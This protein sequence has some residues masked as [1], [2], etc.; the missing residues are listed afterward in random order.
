MA[1]FGFGK[2]AP[3]RIEP[4]FTPRASLENPATSLSDPAQWFTDWATGGNGQSFGPAI[5]ERTAMAVSAVYRCVT[6]YMGVIAGLSPKVYQRTPDGRVEV[7]GN[8]LARLLNVA[9]YPGRS[10]T[11]FAWRELAVCNVLLWGNHYSII[12]YDN[13]ARVIGFEPVMPWSVEVFRRA[14]R[15]IYRC[16][17]EDGSVE[18]IDQ[19]D[20]LH[21][22][23]PGF[24]GILGQSRIASQARDA[25]ALA[26][27]LEQQT[28]KI[29]ENAAR[30]SGVM[31][32]PDKI[33]PE[34]MAR[35]R[36]QFSQQHAGR[37]NAGK[38]IF[39]AKD[40]KF[41][42]IQLSPVDLATI[43]SR[44]YQVAD[45]SRFFGVPLHL[46]NETDKSTSWGSGLA[47]QNLAWL[48]YG[49]DAEICRIEAELNY[50]LMDGTDTYIE[51]HRD[52]LLQMDPA[53]SA[54]VAR[55]EISTGTLTINEY[56]RM[57]NRPP[58]EGGDRPLV[59][60]TNIPLDI[61]LNP[62]QPAPAPAP[63][64][65]TPDA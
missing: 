19:S 20:M 61:A 7:S 23:G 16:T 39:A 62:P 59:N 34:G 13:A 55:T 35:M 31:E 18:V 51:F 2:T 60:S 36:E 64:E 4:T 57:K 12:R 8:R 42:A 28:G 47:E 5:N 45:I 43:E 46:L 33:S 40:T 3:A 37:D 24:D 53:K 50:K 17:L 15:N 26:K 6:L 32:L 65:D 54:E 52:A 27:V 10:L 1:I 30:P 21:F 25:V 44:R 63:N 56:R 11:S 41:T 49:L 38:V 48:I 58:V 9:P 14:G 22:A 29:H